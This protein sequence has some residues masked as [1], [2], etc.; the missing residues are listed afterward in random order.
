VS[1]SIIEMYDRG[2]ERAS[3]IS[4][5]VSRENWLKISDRV[6]QL[7]QELSL[8]EEGLANATQEI[9][10]LKAQVVGLQNQLRVMAIFSEQQAATAVLNSSTCPK[11]RQPMLNIPRMGIHHV[12]PSEPQSYKP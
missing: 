2:F 1:D 11:C 9:E 4:I 8:A 12:C 5:M 6:T 3:I 7:R 10:Q